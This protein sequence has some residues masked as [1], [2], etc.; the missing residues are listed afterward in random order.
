MNKSLICLLGFLAIFDI[1]AEEANKEDMSDPMAVYSGGEVTA[2]SR[3][4]GAAF[5]FGIKR[6]DWGFLGKIE[7]KDN[8]ESYRT[9][10]SHQTSQLGQEF[11][12]MLDM[13]FQILK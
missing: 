2:G 9:R 7:S 11:L 12:S 4:L 5:Q 10:F 8:F 3:G 1:Q 6:G 13:T